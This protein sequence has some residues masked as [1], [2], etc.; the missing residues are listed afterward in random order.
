MM[1][2]KELVGLVGWS[3]ASAISLDLVMVILN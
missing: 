2:R 3:G 1:K